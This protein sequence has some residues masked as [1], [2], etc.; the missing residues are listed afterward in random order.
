MSKA[1][2]MPMYWDAYIADTTHLTIDEHGAYM[3]LLGAM[4]RRDG[5]IPNDDK[6]IARILGVTVAK[7]KKIKARLNGFLTIDDDKISQ[8]KLQKVWKKT[9]EKIAKN[10]ENG[11]KGGRPKSNKNNDLGKANGS[12]SL[13][14]NESIPEPEPKKEKELSKDSS[15]KRGSRLPDDWLAPKE[16]IDWPIQNLNWNLNRTQG[17]LSQFKDY[18]IGL[19]GARAV[20]RDWLATWRNWC[21]NSDKRSP[22]KPQEPSL[23]EMAARAWCEP[24]TDGRTQDENQGPIIDSPLRLVSSSAK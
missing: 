19:S 21:R 6:D 15:K 12:N 2:A 5:S 1:P 9:Q 14:P 13:N 18:W 23:A 3:L 7:W 4:W 24:Q 20:K 10:S 17:Q 11:A 8:E 16:F 22:T